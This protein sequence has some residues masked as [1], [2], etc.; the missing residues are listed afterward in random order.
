MWDCHF[1]QMEDNP[2]MEAVSYWC[3]VNALRNRLP[4]DALLQP[5]LVNVMGMLIE[6][7]VAMRAGLNPSRCTTPSARWRTST[8]SSTRPSTRGCAGGARRCTRS[9]CTID[10]SSPL[11]AIEQPL[12]LTASAEGRV[13]CC[14]VWCEY[15]VGD[16]KCFEDVPGNWVSVFRNGRF[17]NYKKQLLK[18]KEEP[19]VVKKGDC[20]AATA[21]LNGNLEFQF[22]F[23][24]WCVCSFKGSCCE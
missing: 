6:L 20:V 19:V 13:N 4:E 24:S 11:Y 22:S 1:Y 16:R 23:S 14:V 2:V 5:S 8:G 12:A 21:V 17:E 9:R 15:Y 7:G 10:F 3:C 18:F